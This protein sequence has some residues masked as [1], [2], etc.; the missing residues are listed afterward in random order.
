MHFFSFSLS[1]ILHWVKLL[2][3]S[4]N[5]GV[6]CHNSWMLLKAICCLM[7]EKIP[8]WNVCLFILTWYS[9]LIIYSS[10][11]FACKVCSSFIFLVAKTWQEKV[12]YILDIICVAPV[13]R[14]KEREK[15]AYFFS[16]DALQ[17]K[18]LKRIIHTV[19]EVLMVFLM[20]NFAFLT[21]KVKKMLWILTWTLCESVRY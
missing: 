8:R 10:L 17:E 14:E 4:C 11:F 7:K 1:V 18:V 13:S 20:L 16:I 6:Y 21:M 12:E 2:F 9:K 3:K 5:Y 19:K 15:Q